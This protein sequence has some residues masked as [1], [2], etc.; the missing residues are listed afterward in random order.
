MQKVYHL[1]FESEYFKE[2]G[3][4]LELY[5][6]YEKMVRRYVVFGFIVNKY[7]VNGT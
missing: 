4:L 3:Q 6:D 2:T 5:V 7:R 1:G